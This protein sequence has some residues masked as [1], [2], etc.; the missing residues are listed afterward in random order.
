MLCILVL[1]FSSVAY[2]D[3]HEGN[4]SYMM[5]ALE[6]TGDHSILIT[7]IKKSGLEKLFSQDSKV[8]RTL[9]APTDEAFNKL[10]QI[11]SDEF[12]VKNNKNALRK[13]ILNHVFAGTHSTDNVK[14]TGTL[15][16]NLDGK[17]LKMEM[18]RYYSP[19]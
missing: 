13:L 5:K 11:L 14:A 15:T 16:V 10:P 1:Y 9:Y 18:N 4:Q 17:I 6:Q 8:P 19:S 12:F 7:A 2:A 3:H